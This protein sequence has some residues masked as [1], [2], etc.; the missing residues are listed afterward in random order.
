MKVLTEVR[1]EAIVEAASTLF[2]E[3]GYEGASMNE[4]A[5]RL[6]GSKATLYRYF[7]SKELLFDAVVRDSSTSHLSKAVADLQASADGA[8]PLASQLLQFGETMLC[9]MTDSA[10][11]LA[12]Y[13]M[14][15]AEAGRSEVGAL[16][17]KAG[18]RDCIVAL[19]SVLKKA[20]ERG[21]LRSLNPEIMAGHFLGLVAAEVQPRLYQRDPE[22]LPMPQ[23]RAMVERAIDMFFRGAAAR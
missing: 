22:A 12:V 3:F 1:R 21:E 8:V 4:L 20:M 10:R 16:F 19:G 13:R 5:T 7:P 15:V 2:Q 14:V 18:P 9:V 17:Y 23:I 11:A 6:R